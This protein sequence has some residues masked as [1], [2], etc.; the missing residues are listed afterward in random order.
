MH[1]SCIHVSNLFHL[2]RPSVLLAPEIR[3]RPAVVLR[4][5]TTFVI[6][7]WLSV[8]VKCREISSDRFCHDQ[9][10]RHYNNNKDYIEEA[11]EA[12]RKIGA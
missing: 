3:Y 9:D 2:L 5:A 7:M 6:F 12:G 1:H 4:Y 10:I 8:G 11:R